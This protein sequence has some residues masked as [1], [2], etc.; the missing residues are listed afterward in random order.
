MDFRIY[1][2]INEGVTETYAKASATVLKAGKLFTLDANKEAIVAVGAS[3]ALGIVIADALAGTTTVEGVSNTDIILD[4]TAAAVFAANQKGLTADVSITPASLLTG[5]AGTVTAATWAAVT[6]GSIRITING[7]AYNVDAINF[8]GDTTMADVAATLQAAIRTATSALETV[9]FNATTSKFTI[10]SV[11]ATA[12]SDVSVL[13]TSTGTV[14]TDISGAS[15]LNGQVGTGVPTPYQQKLNIG[16][17]STNVLKV[18]P[19][20][21][22][23]TVGSALNVKARIALPLS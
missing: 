9:T 2:Q 20:I 17:G 21:T 6:D 19:D 8:T 16:A 3:T 18:V 14:G 11:A 7:T 4:G 22:A 13:S 12:A 5:V 23:G 15:W 10:S 1:N